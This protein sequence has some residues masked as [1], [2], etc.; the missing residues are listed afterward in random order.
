MPKVKTINKVL[1][2]DTFS[3]AFS[4]VNFNPRDKRGVSISQPEASDL[5]NG[6][7]SE[8]ARL[9]NSYL[10]HF[11]DSKYRKFI[12]DLPTHQRK[13]DVDIF[14]Y[15]DS[16]QYQNW[17]SWHN[18]TRTCIEES[19]A[20]LK[21][22]Y[23]RQMIAEVLGQDPDLTYVELKKKLGNKYVKFNLYKN[24]R[25]AVKNGKELQ[26]PNVARPRLG[27]GMDSDIMTELCEN[28]IL[29]KHVH[30]QEYTLDLFFPYHRSCSE[31]TPT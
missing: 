2:L 30:V 9:Q 11:S 3:A 14:K 19:V 1:S 7:I 5:L 17:R 27:L 28:G 25:R 15:V 13:K 22:Y 24:V 23:Q 12:L 20:K 8:C 21:G 4:N 16:I 26:T 10:Q 29:L 31:N 6:L 18:L